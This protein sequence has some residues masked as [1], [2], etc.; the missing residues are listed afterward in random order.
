ML[1]PRNTR[2]DIRVV[3]LHRQRVPIFSCGLASARLVP[4]TQ[5]RGLYTILFIADVCVLLAQPL[6]RVCALAGQRKLRPATE[7]TESLPG[8]ASRPSPM[9][10]YPVCMHT[11]TQQFHL[12]CLSLTWCACVCVCVC[13]LCV[14]FCVLCVVCC[15]VRVWRGASRAWNARACLRLGLSL[16]PP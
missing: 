7:Q 6:Q 16:Q 4:D 10:S 14:M 11:H 13:V 5:T 9:C 8:A 1:T 2:T 12:M 15:A 3:F